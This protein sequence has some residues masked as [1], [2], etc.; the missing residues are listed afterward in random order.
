MLSPDQIE[1]LKAGMN[2]NTAVPSNT[3]PATHDW[4]DSL[5]GGAKPATDIFSNSA[6]GAKARGATSFANSSL[7]K[8]FVDTFK[9]G[10]EAVTKD[11][12]NTGNVAEQAGGG[13]GAKVLSGLSTAGHVAGDIAGT[14]GGLIGDVIAPLLPESVKTGIGNLAQTIN[15]KVDKIPGMT[16]EIHKSLSD[17]FNTLT[18]AGGGEAEP[19]ITSVAKAGAEKATTLAKQGVEKISE[20]T[21]KIKTALTKTPEE[22]TAQS[23][24]NI[25][26]SYTKG[27]KPSVSGKGTANQVAS[28]NKNAVDAIKTIAQNKDKLNITDEFGDTTGKLPENPREFGQAIEQTKQEIFNQYDSLA[29]SAGEAGAKVELKPVVSELQKL[30]K[31][32]VVNDLHPELAKYAIDRAKTLTSRGSYSTGEAQ[33]AVQNLNKSLESF[34]KNPS[35]E[36]ASKASVDAMIANNLRTGLDEAISSAKGPG[37][38]ELKSKYGSLK[39]I[40]KDVN[41]RAQVA[42]R[43]TSGGLTFGDVFSAEEVIRGLAT[44]NPGAIATGVGVKGATTLWKY[45]NNPDRYIKDIFNEASKSTSMGQNASLPTNALE[46]SK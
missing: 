8:S 16:P 12:T 25:L 40:E 43:K 20:G 5:V 15:E 33:Q 39:T 27:I 9:K 28:Y 6:E 36:T 32:K 19:G 18:L 17:V 21:T 38:A 1:T 13:V 23:D 37:Y 34:Y 24:K 2:T 41:K 29:K 26:D 35:Y 30:A 7:G 3:A 46:Q 10:G 22:L 42:A 44:M 45:F 4:V 14:A 31:D 11:I